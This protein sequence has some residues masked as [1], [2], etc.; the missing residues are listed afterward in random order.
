MELRKCINAQKIDL[1]MHQNFI[2]TPLGNQCTMLLFYCLISSITLIS[3][4]GIY[5]ILVQYSY[6]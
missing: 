5:I 2:I 3:R 1:N 6:S 4:A